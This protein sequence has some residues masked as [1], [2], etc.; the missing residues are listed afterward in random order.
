MRKLYYKPHV[1]S[2]MVLFQL[3]PDTI[4]T[5]YTRYYIT[6]THTYNI[7]FIGMMIVNNYVIIFQ[8]LYVE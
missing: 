8:N 4:I 1:I 5:Y 3:L 7:L 2:V 6:H